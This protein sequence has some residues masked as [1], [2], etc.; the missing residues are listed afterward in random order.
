MTRPESWKLGP[1]LFEYIVA[2]SGRYKIKL[3]GYWRI[4]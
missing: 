3:Y 1:E 4:K 2:S